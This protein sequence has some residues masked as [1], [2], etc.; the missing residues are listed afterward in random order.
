MTRNGLAIIAM[1][2]VLLLAAAGGFWAMFFPAD[3]PAP[4]TAA[5]SPVFDTAP[6]AAL[7]GA[8]GAPDGAAFDSPA[9]AE[10]PASGRVL[11]PG[12]TDKAP[13]G[14]DALAAIETPAGAAPLLSTPGPAR[15]ASDDQTAAAAASASA[16]AASDPVVA[17]A[18]AAP[19]SNGVAVETPPSSADAAVAAIGGALDPSAR[20]SGAP[21][22]A[23]APEFDL[24]RVAQDGSAVLAGR[25]EPGALITIMVDGK[26][27]ESLRADASGE[28]VALISAPA[29]RAGSDGSMRIDL[30]AVGSNGVSVRSTA[31]V[32]V[33]LPETMTET[34]VAVRPS[35]EGVEVLQPSARDDA[36]RVTIDAVTYGAAGE[37][38]ITG[39]GAPGET[40]RVYLDNSLEAEAAV[41]E[42]GGWRVEIA[43]D[44]S[45][46]VYDLRVDQTDA[47]GL[48]TSRAETPFERAAP[49]E[50]KL[51][52]GAVVVQ[53]GNNLWRIADYVYGSGERYTVIYRTNRDQIRNP[54]L[55]Y[56]GQILT[57]PEQEG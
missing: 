24:V 40:A 17:S 16:D 43:R 57:L 38:V 44:V 34:P 53:P 37:V 25:A 52:K 23:P 3:A 51:Q 31:P 21:R 42:T 30:S 13:P 27:A 7:S 11:R 41:A 22:R 49:S 4:Q 54:D 1:V 47:A 39:R 26:P 19:P 45:P 48:V 29:R 15:P 56:P 28:F 14:S 32:I 5:T 9:T 10:V 20:A 46:A 18:R 33:A 55:I 50:F 8:R 35:E 6:P 36:A 12:P 2:S